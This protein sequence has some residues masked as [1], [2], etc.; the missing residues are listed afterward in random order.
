MVV[1]LYKM[2]SRRCPMH[3]SLGLQGEFFIRTHR[4]Y[5]KYRLS[6]EVLS[7]VS[8][9]THLQRVWLGYGGAFV[10]E[11][12][13]GQYFRNLKGHYPG[14]EAELSIDLSIKVRETSTRLRRIAH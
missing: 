5:L 9:P 3:V 2:Q 8:N 1:W 12:S 13:W 7:T 10:V 4:H 6:P 14:L 11:T